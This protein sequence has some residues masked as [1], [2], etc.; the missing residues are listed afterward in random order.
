MSSSKD[1]SVDQALASVPDLLSDL[2]RKRSHQL[3]SNVAEGG[4]EHRELAHAAALIGQDYRDRFLIEL[5]Q[6]AN[7]QALLAG[8]GRSTVV[9]VRSASLLAV[10]NG[11]QVVTARNL[12]R[13]SSLAD[14]DKTGV[15]VG[16]KGVGFKAVY[17]VTDAPE[18]YSASPASGGIPQRSLFDQFGIGIALEQSPF[19]DPT[20]RAFVEAEVTAFFRA[21]A[22]LDASLRTR[23]SEDPLHLVRAEYPHVA[24]F[25]FP[26]PRGPA[27]LQSRIV[28]L[29]FPD[30]LGRHVQTLVVLP[31]RDPATSADVEGAVDRLVGTDASGVT[32]A[33]LGLLFLSGIESLV[34]V[35]RVRDRTWVLVRG[36]TSE[37]DGIKR[38]T[39]A[40]T[41]P[42]GSVRRQRYWLLQRDAL[43]CDPETAAA[44]KKTITEALATFRLEAWNLD[45]PLPVTVAIPAPNGTSVESLGP[46]GV[47][48]L[49]LPT[50]QSTGLPVHVD[51]RFFATI[52]RTGLDFEQTYNAMLLEVAASVLG[53]LLSSLRLSKALRTRRAATLAFARTPGALADKAFAADG[54]ADGDVVLSWDGKTFVPRA[55][56]PLPNA[57]ERAMLPFLVTAIEE[58]ERPVRELPEV[59][60]MMHASPALESLGLP[61]MS[62]APHPWLLASPECPS[63]L[64]RAARANRGGDFRVWEPFVA[65]VLGCF[66]APLLEQI[67]WLPVGTAELA[68][69]DEGVFLPAHVDTKA[70]DDEVSVV[71]SHVASRLRLLDDR[72]LRLRQDGRVLTKSASRLLGLRLVRSPRKA[73]LL[74]VALF[75]ALEDAAIADPQGPLAMALFVQALVWINSMKPASVLK[76]DCQRAM[77]PF[78]R[79]DGELAWTRASQLYL[80]DGW[81]LP[82]SQDSLLGLAYP[83]RRLVPFSVMRQRYGLPEGDVRTWRA[84]AERMGVQAWPVVRSFSD[85]PVRPLLSSGYRLY[86]NGAATLGD[87]GL[88]AIYKAY[89]QRLSRGAAHWDWQFEHDVTDVRWIDG[90]EREEGRAHVVD[91]MLAN[92]GKYLPHSTTMLGR[93]G[94]NGPHDEVPQMWHFA[95][96]DLKWPVFAGERGAGNEPTRVTTSRLWRLPEGARRTGYAQ[97]LIVAPNAAASAAPLLRSLGVPSVDEAPLERLFAELLDLAKRLDI[98]LLHTRNDALSLAK[99]LYARIDER[100]ANEAME[101]APPDVWLPLFHDRRLWAIDPRLPTARI[102]FDDDLA[103]ARYVIGAEEAYKVPISRDTSIDRIHA[104]F[105]RSWGAVRVLRTSTAPIALEFDKA[106][107]GSTQVP[108]LEWIQATYPQVDVAPQLAALLTYG[109]ERTLTSERLTRH[110]K[111]FTNLKLIFGSFNTAGVTSFYN[112]ATE[113]LWL[114]SSLSPHEVVAAT[115]ELAGQRTRDL[116]AG[117]GRALLAHAS[118]AFLHERG[119]TDVEIVDASDEAGLHR[120]T[121]IQALAPALLAARVHMSPGTSLDGAASWLAGLGTRVEDVANA[122]G[123][124]DLVQVLTAAVALRP[125]EGE[126]AVLRHLGVPIP[127]WQEAIE[128]RDGRRYIFSGTVRRYTEVVKHFAAVAR[129]IAARSGSTDLGAIGIELTRLLAAPTP[130]AVATLPLEGAQADAAALAA[131]LSSLAGFPSVVRPL[132]SIAKP[133]WQGDLPLPEEASRRGVRLY[134][135]VPQQTR[136]IDAST[137]VRAVVEVA[138]RLAAGLNEQVDSARLLADVDLQL[139]IK[140]E[141]AHVYAALWRLRQL[142]ETLAPETVRTLSSVQAFRDSSTV[143]SLL[144]KLPTVSREGTEVVEKKYTLLGQSL[145]DSEIRNQLLAGTSGTLGSMLVTAARLP[146]DPNVAAG[147]RIPLPPAGDGTS[148]KRG[149]GGGGRG[150]AKS[151]RE[152]EIIGDIGEAFFHEWLSARLESDYGADCWV[153]HARARYGFPPA[154]ND[155]LGYDFRVSDPTGSLFGK[156]ATTFLIEVKSTST[157]GAGSFPMTRHEWEQ[158]RRCHEADGVEVYA[159]VRIFS[160]NDKPRIGDVIVDPFSGLLNGSVR[161]AERDLWVTVAPL[162]DGIDQ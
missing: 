8:S 36:K 160:T 4:R 3:A 23:T 116:L 82:A 29:G 7:D 136:E 87:E 138:A 122:L 54:I 39:I 98:E 149:A 129:E 20:L 1:P 156:P 84:G 24:G 53:E 55:T 12:E 78:I 114:S 16:N 18:V 26:L 159:I 33:E 118:R 30:D 126:L 99:E 109:G 34:V 143:S 100:L 94:H 103:R 125:P 9:V 95:L 83:S 27:E 28:D 59:G 140:G 66:Q 154:G 110:W 10:S 133:P 141:W 17:H 68:A 85:R 105:V 15:L 145:T 13:L 131:T 155:D 79:S 62:A 146:L 150:S 144:A 120:A 65:A 161:L 2:W 81:G 56:C 124:P 127:L 80:G 63:I 106:G 49:G 47:F 102:V 93:V 96:T 19:R 88:E 61:A 123:Q 44:R 139:R 6:N 75:P 113:E 119:I 74:E 35:D 38:A 90:L 162:V 153:S 60:L 108:F 117:F 148:G 121:D 135:E 5:I 14:S 97:Q 31:L 21:N 43:D 45:D 134:L 71:P 42:D 51:A 46:P 132:A 111:E 57:A 70:D 73:D 147:V 157:D 64:E 32:E 50:Q 104:L 86:V 41:R 89:I 77:A 142:V 158:A 112:R 48:C 91:L 40:A 69:P 115:W 76:L 101:S 107:L 151:N 25:K 52:S 67:S 130:T 37:V 11:G 137:S 72:A 58:D 92:H 22:G 128:R 152:T